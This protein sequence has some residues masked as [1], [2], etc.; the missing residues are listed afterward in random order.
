MSTPYDPP[1]SEL[2][3][4]SE[5]SSIDKQGSLESGINGEFSFTISEVISEAWRL[6]KGAKLQLFLGIVIAYSIILALTFLLQL[7]GL[8][9]APYI[10]RGEYGLGILF[11]FLPGLIILPI[12]AP[13]FTGWM[14][15]GIK[16]AAGKPTTIGEL[17]AYF[18]KVGPL[19]VAY[20]IM[21]VCIMIGF[22]LLIFPGIYLSIAY[23]FTWPLIVEKGLSPWQALEASR[24]AITHCWF[25]SLGLFTLLSLLMILATFA[26][27]IGLLWAIPLMMLAYGVLYRIIFGVSEVN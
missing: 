24:K 19:V 16:R 22:L 11:S 4:E 25:R 1:K 8:D 13:L 5:P 15:I 12:S 10:E 21:Y 6:V 26:L 14:M 2:Q 17:F 7:I 20:L 27:L 3:I 9:G 23:I 18:P